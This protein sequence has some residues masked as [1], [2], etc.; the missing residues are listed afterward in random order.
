M[1]WENKL[2]EV[3]NHLYNRK[4]FWIGSAGASRFKYINIRVDTRDN[5]CLLSDRDG[6]PFEYEQLLSLKDNVM[7]SPGIDE[8]SKNEETNLRKQI[9]DLQDE[10]SDLKREIEDIKIWGD[11][12]E[13]HSQF[14]REGF[15]N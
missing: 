5:A 9:E 3:V 2:K 1:T 6:N 14:N 13:E 8:I 4:W 10:V 11:R 12:L 7:M 15:I